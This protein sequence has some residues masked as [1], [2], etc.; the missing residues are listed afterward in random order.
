M[1]IGRRNI[2]LSGAAAA[3]GYPARRTQAAHGNAVPAGTP[4]RWAVLDRQVSL[5]LGYYNAWVFQAR[6]TRGAAQASWC[7]PPPA[8]SC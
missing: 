8:T 2:I 4:S 6:T 3:A 5:A 7:H 1:L